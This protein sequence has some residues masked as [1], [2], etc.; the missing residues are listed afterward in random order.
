V[1]S[2]GCISEEFD[3]KAIAVP[4]A[5]L[6]AEVDECFV[7]STDGDGVDALGHKENLGGRD[8]VVKLVGEFSEF[9]DVLSGGDDELKLEGV[10]VGPFVEC[11]EV[12]AS[13]VVALDPVVG[14]F[15]RLWGGV[16][17]FRTNG[18]EIAG[19]AFGWN[20]AG[21]L[22]GYVVAVRFELG[23]EIGHAFGD[24]GFTSRHDDVPGTMLVHFNDNI[25]NGHVGA[26]R[27]PGCVF[28]VAP[29]TTEIASRRANKDGGHAGEFALALYRE[30]YF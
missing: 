3:V 25:L 23:E 22:D 8:L 28:G 27:I 16:G 9:S 14:D 12:N 5:E 15:S 18:G 10:V 29:S 7:P 11:V 13:G 17:K 1:L 4:V 24:H 20:R 21:G 30:K 2:S 26:S 19:D 6:L